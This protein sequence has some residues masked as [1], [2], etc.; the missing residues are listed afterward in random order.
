MV[1]ASRHIKAEQR[2]QINKLIIN[3]KLFIMESVRELLNELNTYSVKDANAINKKVLFKNGIEATYHVKNN[4]R[5][6]DMVFQAVLVISYKN[7]EPI[8][9]GCTTNEDNYQVVRWFERKDAGMLQKKNKERETDTRILASL[10]DV[11][12]L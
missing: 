3:L 4:L 2:K 9:W 8:T 1:V 6:E 11:S 5:N 10:I 7:S 12:K